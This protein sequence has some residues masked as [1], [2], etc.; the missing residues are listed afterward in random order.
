MFFQ[1]NH[2][3][4]EVYKTAREL[5]KE[6]YIITKILPSQEKYNLTQQI[7]RVILSVKLNVAEGSSR[8]SESERKRYYEISRRSIIEIDSAFDLVIIKL[9]QLTS[10]GLL[11]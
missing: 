1:L 2:K 4:I 5:L 8:K 3:N 6:C 10:I 7:R 11:I 9:D